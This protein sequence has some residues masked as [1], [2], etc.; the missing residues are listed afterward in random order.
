MFEGADQGFRV[1]GVLI[2][3]G[4]RLARGRY[5]SVGEVLDE[6]FDYKVF[7]LCELAGTV[8]GLF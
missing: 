3:E 6:V 2:G 5:G 8:Y 4:S 1:E 7:T